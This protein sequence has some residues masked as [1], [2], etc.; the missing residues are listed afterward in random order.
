MIQLIAVHEP[1]PEK[2]AMWLWQNK[3]SFRQYSEGMARYKQPEL[4]IPPT[5]E[6]PSLISRF[7]KIVWII[8]RTLLF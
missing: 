4:A 5:P 6:K 1:T 3:I 7:K 8:R 2:L